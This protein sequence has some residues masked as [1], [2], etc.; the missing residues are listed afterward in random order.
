ML[1]TKTLLRKGQNSSI[2][3][4]LKSGNWLYFY[5]FNLIVF[6][7][8]FHCLFISTVTNLCVEATQNLTGDFQMYFA[9]VELPDG[10]VACV[11]QCDINHPEPKTC[12]H[13]GTCAVDKQGPNC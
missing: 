5:L 7:I 10:R 13:G 12:M 8:Y 9:G 4:L 1:E 3:F 11:T 2:D 6:I